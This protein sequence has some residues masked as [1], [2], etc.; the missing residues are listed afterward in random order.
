MRGNFPEIKSQLSRSLENNSSIRGFQDGDE[1][2]G[3][4]ADAMNQDIVEHIQ[5]YSAFN[6]IQCEFHKACEEGASLIY[7]GQIPPV[8]SMDNTRMFH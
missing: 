4:L 2:Q 6:K 1:V 7:S 8:N 5:L 3:Q